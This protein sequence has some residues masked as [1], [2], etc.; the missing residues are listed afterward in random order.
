[1]SDGKVRRWGYRNGDAQIFELEP[2]ENL[3]EGWVDSPAKTGEGAA[4]VA[5]EPVT[6]TK[7]ENTPK[8]AEI[9]GLHA[10]IAGLKGELEQAYA[11]IEEL[12]AELSTPK[13]VPDD[14][15]D[16]DAANEKEGVID[17]DFIEIPDDWNTSAMHHSTR[18]KLAK[19]LPGGDEVNSNDDAIAVIELELERRASD[20]S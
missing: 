3:P 1:M 10:E 12:K 13:S 8:D 2:G 17:A 20:D 6:E 18:I 14:V 5:P 7:P 16:W 15:R 9:D 19:Q 11:Q 4:D